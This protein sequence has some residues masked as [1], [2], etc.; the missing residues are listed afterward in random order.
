MFF[1]TPLEISMLDP[2]IFDRVRV[3]LVEERFFKD[4]DTGAPLQEEMIEITP[5]LIK[6]KS[7][8]SSVKV[9]VSPTISSKNQSANRFALPPDAVVSTVTIRSLTNCQG[10]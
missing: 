7:E 5:K 9:D 2:G 8:S 10:S 1:D 3:R 4:P 6:F